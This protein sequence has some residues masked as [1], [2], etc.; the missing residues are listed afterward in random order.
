LTHPLQNEGII[1]FGVFEFRHVC[2][3]NYVRQTEI[4]TIEP[5]VPDSSTFEVDVVIQILKRYRSSDIDQ[6]PAE[7]TQS[8]SKTLCPK[9]IVARGWGFNY[10]SSLLRRI[11][12]VKKPIIVIIMTHNKILL[13]IMMFVHR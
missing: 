5:L 8:R 2:G 13:N 9:I 10:C 7:M 1:N 4:C 6:I 3:F 12:R 11:R